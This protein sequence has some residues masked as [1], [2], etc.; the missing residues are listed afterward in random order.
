MLIGAGWYFI[1]NFSEIVENL[2]NISFYKLIISFLFLLF[3]KV[4][5]SNLTWQS[6][7]MIPHKISFKE[8]FSISTITQLGKYLPG[9]IWHF[10][11]KF[12]VYKTR[13]LTT[14]DA[15]RAMIIENLWLFSSALVTGIFALLTSKNEIGCSFLNLLCDQ[16]FRT[17]LSFGV[18]I[19][20]ITI[21]IL[22]QKYVFTKDT[23]IPS[24]IRLILKQVLAWVLFGISL[25]LIFPSNPDPDFLLMTIGAFCISWIVGYAAIF[26][27]GGIGIREATLTL[28]LGAFFIGEPVTI[29]ASIHRLLWVLVEI[30]LGAGSALV[31]GIPLGM[32][33]TKNSNLE[34]S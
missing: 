21:L 28:I 34:E 22:F 5:T 30:L 31:F 3:G 27:P 2:S 15:T 32:E 4:L 26:A 12:G 29:F 1:N 13:G 20:W 6:L 7:K 14:K 24:L 17:I 9:G 25:W 16:Q 19:F 8:A 10:A 18:P 33:P 23:N 11:G